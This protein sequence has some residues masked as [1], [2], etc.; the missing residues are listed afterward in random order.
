MNSSLSFP[1]IVGV[2]PGK[3]ATATT[4]L[5]RGIESFDPPP[6]RHAAALYAD[7][8]FAP[9]AFERSIIMYI[10]SQESPCA[11]TVIAV[12]ELLESSEKATR[13]K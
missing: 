9:C 1:T 4:H 7:S 13:L 2:L 3:H 8:A 5:K 12:P 11:A 10:S 6:V